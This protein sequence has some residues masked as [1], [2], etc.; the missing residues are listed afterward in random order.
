MSCRPNI[1]SS[2][3]LNLHSNTETPFH[4]NDH[5][6]GVVVTFAILNFFDVVY[7]T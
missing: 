4:L 7:V 5:G 2:E 1:P 3:V 6:F